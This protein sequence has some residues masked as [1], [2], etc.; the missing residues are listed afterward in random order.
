MWNI[1]RDRRMAGRGRGQW[2]MQRSCPSEGRRGRKRWWKARRDQ[3]R[4]GKL[5]QEKVWWSKKGTLKR[6][7]K[8]QLFS[9]K[10]FQ[11]KRLF[12]NTD[13]LHCIV[14]QQQSSKIM[15]AYCIMRQERDEVALLTGRIKTWESLGS[16]SLSDC[17]DSSLL[18]TARPKLDLLHHIIKPKSQCY[19]LSTLVGPW[20]LWYSSP[21]VCYKRMKFWK[22]G[23]D[24]Q[25]PVT[26]L[27][28]FLL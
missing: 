1:Y 2:P 8:N 23:M 21:W 20:L 13:I 28:R 9:T 15:S 7:Q 10:G 17:S 12:T 4:P 22:D 11:R 24:T 16:F 14:M 27:L 18:S 6:R 19:S 26:A 25:I 3:Q 5:R